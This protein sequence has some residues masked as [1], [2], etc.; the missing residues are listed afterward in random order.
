MTDFYGIGPAI[1]ASVVMYQTCARGSG[2]TLSLLNS[3]KDGDRVVFTNVKQMRDFERQA[4]ERGINL[5]YM[6]V[7]PATPN[8]ILERRPSQGRT[9]FDHSWVEQYF[10]NAIERAEKDINRFQTV[11]SGCSE[12]PLET[13]HKALER[14]RFREWLR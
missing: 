11:T 12:A 4:K 8:L 5:E 6:V 2:R 10:F 1:K 13:K 14:S 3:L 9:I 7:D